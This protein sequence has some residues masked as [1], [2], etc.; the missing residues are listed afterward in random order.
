MKTLSFVEMNKFK[1]RYAKTNINKQLLIHDS[2]TTSVQDVIC[3]RTNDTSSDISYPS[4][5]YTS[6]KNLDDGSASTIFEG[7]DN[8]KKC[9]VIIKKISK[10]ECWRTE[11]E[12]LKKLSENNSERLLKYLD[13]FE[14]QR[15]SYI[16]TEFYEGSD[17]F[18]H[19]DLN[20]PYSEKKGLL[21]CLEM[22]KCI[23]ECH[24]NNIIHLDIKCENYM[25]KSDKLFEEHRPNIVLID[26]GH[27]EIIPKDIPIEK[28]R[29]GYSYGTKYYTCPE[30]YI[31]KIHSSKSDIWSLMICLS[32]L[33]TGD[34]P[35]LG[36]GDEYY[37]NSITDKISLTKKINPK[38]EKVIVDGLSSIPNKRPNID[39]IIF[40]LSNIA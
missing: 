37:R 32:T 24:D 18:E 30:G 4:I 12:V 28:L 7:F 6:I 21:L 14:S 31:E 33:L 17:L 11:L 35:F 23:K 3:T 13:F 34:F 27:A 15:C 2:P 19:I 9:K 1:G 40:S 39:E 10:K 38:I 29:K 26:F 22:A 16:I 36:R 25:V 20:V 8:Q 5:R